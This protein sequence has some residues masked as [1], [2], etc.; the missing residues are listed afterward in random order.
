MTRDD[1]MTSRRMAEAVQRRTIWDTFTSV[2]ERDAFIHR[3]AE[4]RKTHGMSNH[5]LYSVW[6]A[7]KF[8]CYNPKHPAFQNWGGRGIKIC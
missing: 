6:K 1:V 4:K 3:R 8:R 2:E 5:P 7:M